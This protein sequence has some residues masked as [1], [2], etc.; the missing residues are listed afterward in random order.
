MQRRNNYSAELE[1]KEVAL[2]NQPGARSTRPADIGD[3]AVPGN[4]KDDLI[5]GSGNTNIAALVESPS[6]FAMPRDVLMF[7]AMWQRVSRRAT[8]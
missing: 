4:W 3:R 2:A 1:R 7:Q 6:R 5:A 8:Y